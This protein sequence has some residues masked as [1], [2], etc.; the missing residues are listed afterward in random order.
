MK[1]VK[2]RIY[3]IV[4]Y[5]VILFLSN[6]FFSSLAYNFAVLVAPLI[7]NLPVFIYNLIVAVLMI[8]ISGVLPLIAIFLYL[9]W[10]VPTQYRV[11]EEVKIWRKSAALLVLPSELV[12]MIICISQLGLINKGGR[13]ALVPSILFEQI[14]LKLFPERMIPVRQNLEFVFADYISY[15]V[16]YLLYV[17]LFLTVVFLEY[18]YFW[19]KVKR[20]R[21]EE[22]IVY[23]SCKRPY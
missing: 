21:E 7:I 10:C 16:C 1:L 9:R 15:V 5:G 6:I 23:D 19:K 4:L 8:L 14:Y 11:T 18:N 22:L 13:L 2:V 17:S 20:E 12:R 3:Q